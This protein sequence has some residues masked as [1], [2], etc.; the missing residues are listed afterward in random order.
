MEPIR[1]VRGAATGPT[2]TASYDEALAE[3]GVENYNLTAV[4][5]VIPAGAT[6]EVAETA[7]DLGPAGERLTVV[8]GRRTVAPGEAD[9]AVAGLGWS[10]EATGRGIFYEASGT[11]EAT[12]RETVADG[13]AA[14]RSLRPDW[15]FVD[16]GRE[17]L[18]VAAD[19]AA[20]TTAL[21]LAVYGDSDPIL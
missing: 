5:S 1:V 11:D 12:V 3:A 2:A 20:Y 6:V 18:A 10:V 17:F 8:Q 14:G 15:A 7:P 13:L 21:V 16:D 9:R 19:E 4:S